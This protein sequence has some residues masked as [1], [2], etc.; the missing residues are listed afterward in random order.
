MRNFSYFCHRREGPES[1][2]RSF[3]SSQE[4]YVLTSISFLSGTKG[5][6]T[7]RSRVPDKLI[8]N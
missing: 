3:V 7:Q 4:F 8:V 6:I 2:L 1:S 5:K